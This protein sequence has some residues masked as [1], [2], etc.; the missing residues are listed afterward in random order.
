MEV[1]DQRHDICVSEEMNV[2]VSLVNE[3]WCG[4]EMPKGMTKLRCDF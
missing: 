2:A 4:V 3:N 1:K